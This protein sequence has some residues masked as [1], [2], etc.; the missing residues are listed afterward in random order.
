MEGKILIFKAVIL[1]LFLLIC[2]VFIPPR[3]VILSVERAFFYF[4]WGSKWERVRKEVLK[5]PKEKG[6]RGV[7]DLP[8]FLGARFTAQ[9][10]A[11]CKENTRNPKTTAFIKFWMGS[12]L[13]KMT[14]LTIDLRVPVSFNLPKFYDFIPTFLRNFKLE[15]E[16]WQVLTNHRFIISV[17]QERETVSPVCASPKQFGAT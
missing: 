9:H 14:F 3:A 12:F 6:G 10:L 17:V 13:R 1:P 5:K 4:L 2:S 8:L 15:Q 7:P 16:E 11:L